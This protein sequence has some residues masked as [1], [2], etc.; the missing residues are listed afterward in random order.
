MQKHISEWLSEDTLHKAKGKTRIQIFQ[1]FGNKLEPVAY[2]LPEYLQYLGDNI[3]DNRVYSGKG[4][5]IDHALNHHPE[6]PIEMYFEIQNI[7]CNPDDVKLDN[8]KVNKKSLVFIKEYDSFYQVVVAVDETEEGKFLVHKTFN[9]HHKKPYAGLPGIRSS[10]SSLV[11]GTTTISHT[12]SS[13]P[14]SPLSALNDV[15]K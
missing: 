5:F 7:L 12:E 14:G 6:V 1:E 2:M 3:K 13:A 8:R 15:Q 10:L 9:Y 11:G 4:Y